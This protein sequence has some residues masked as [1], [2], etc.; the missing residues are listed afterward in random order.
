MPLY[1][2]P[3]VASP[4]QPR[5]HTPLSH[6]FWTRPHTVFQITHIISDSS[7]SAKRSRPFPS[8]T[9]QPL[10][11]RQLDQS[12]PARLKPTP[13]TQ[14]RP[15]AIAPDPSCGPSYCYKPG[16]ILHLQ[17]S[18]KPT[19]VSAT[20]LQAHVQTTGPRFILRP[21]KPFTAN[22]QTPPLGFSK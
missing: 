8:L 7:D 14:L 5:P 16:A 19:L 10:P 20:W 2:Y 6:A 12:R 13:N 22:H 17:L 1:Y 18:R 9:C 15:S 3:T 11:R 21:R 4:S